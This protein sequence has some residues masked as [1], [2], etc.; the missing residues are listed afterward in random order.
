MNT[1]KVQ[2]ATCHKFFDKPTN[3][4]NRTERQGKRHFCS[5]SCSSTSNIDVLKPYWKFNKDKLIHKG[6]QDEYSPFRWHLR[7]IRRHC[8]QKN[9]EF[10][11]TL[12]DL[13]EQ[14]DKQNGICIYTGLQMINSPYVMNHQERAFNRASVDRIDSSKG[15]TKDNIHF[16]TMMANLAKNSWTEQ[17]LLDFCKLVVEYRKL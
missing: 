3:Q 12:Q 7:N 13:K 15:Y 16:V 1:T 10:A 2:C 5:R 9:K 6:P 14:W 4:Y 17:Q 8:K 11:I